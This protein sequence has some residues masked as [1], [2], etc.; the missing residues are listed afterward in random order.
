M[1]RRLVRK[2]LR[3]AERFRVG[4]RPFG[5][6]LI[7]HRVASPLADPWNMAVSPENFAAH[8]EIL[9]RFAVP[10]TMRD[11]AADLSNAGAPKRSIAVTFDDGYVDNLSTALPLM[12]AH[13][14]PGSVF[15]ISGAI[16]K[17]DAFWWDL[18]VQVFL[19]MPHLP[20]SLTIE[21]DGIWRRFDLAGVA[22]CGADAMARNAS[23]NADL[24]PPRDGRQRVLLDVW[25]HLLSLT[26]EG[27][28]EAV[29]QIRVWAGATVAFT[30]RDK[31]RPMDYDELARLA[32][33]RLI[34]IGGHTV[35]H[36]DLAQLSPGLACIEIARGRAD[37]MEWTGQ[38]VDSFAYPYGRYSE[39]P[40]AQIRE[41][42]FSY[43]AWSHPGLAT[44]SSEAFT[45]PRLHITNLNGDAFA[46]LLRDV[47][48]PP[49]VSI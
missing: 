15:V 41:A 48:G 45:L 37:L 22:I 5:V 27:R 12:E 31:P 13:D 2:G 17:P 10:R 47:L 14:V 35:S 4:S 18:L 42:G 20:A 11:L 43:A 28:S 9:K 24:S 1:I 34:E 6:V 30:G 16:G 38:S 39:R 25:N 3:R 26:V 44:S 32:A 29:R 19:G 46:A 21:A 40:S 8:L 7:Y 33:S 49:R 36:P 23:W